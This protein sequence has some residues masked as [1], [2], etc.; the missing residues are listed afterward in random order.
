MFNFK[1]KKILKIKKP[2]I[3]NLISG[4]NNPFLIKDSERERER[5]RERDEILKRF[6]HWFYYIML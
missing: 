5:E 2:L 4:L 6:Y 3:Y 1:L